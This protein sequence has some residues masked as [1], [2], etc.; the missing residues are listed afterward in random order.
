[1]S[2]KTPKQEKYLTIKEASSLLGVSA[3]TLRNWEKRGELVPY[4]NPIN[5]YRMYKVQQVEDFLEDMRI[6]RMRKGKFK[7]KVVSA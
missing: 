3:Q 7:I 6:E 4:R 5:N 1:M 2:T